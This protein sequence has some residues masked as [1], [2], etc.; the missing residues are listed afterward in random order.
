MQDLV[1]LLLRLVHLPLLL[2]IATTN[3]ISGLFSHEL[4][5]LLRERVVVDGDPVAQV[6]AHVHV[7]AHQKWRHSL[8]F[9]LIPAVLVDVDE[10]VG[11]FR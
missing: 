6:S 10:G 2:M 7:R 9:H 8:L 1:H 5:V 4:F 11:R 3:R